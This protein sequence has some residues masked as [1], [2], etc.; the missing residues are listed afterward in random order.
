MQHSGFQGFRLDLFVP[1]KK[2][3]LKALPKVHQPAAGQLHLQVVVENIDNL[4]NRV[5]QAIVHPG[6]HHCRAVA[7]GSPRQGV[8]NLRFDELLAP[9]APVATNNMF[10]DD[11]RDPFGNVLDEASAEAASVSPGLG[12]R[13]STAIDV[14]VSGRSVR[15]HGAWP[16]CPGLP[17]LL[18]PSARGRFLIAGNHARR[19]GRRRLVGTQR[20]QLPRHDEKT[21]DHRF[22]APAIQL[23][24]LFLRQGRTEKFV[25]TCFRACRAH[26]CLYEH[27]LA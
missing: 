2:S 23:P 9:R 24:G 3:V 16:L 8:G 18:A 21:Q 10:C 20:S 5:A 22:F 1:G 4:R 7:D 14:R 11:G 6:G 17:P 19:R 13:D 27:P 12:N 26:T 15:A 25:E